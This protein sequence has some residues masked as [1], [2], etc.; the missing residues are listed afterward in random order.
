MIALLGRLKIYLGN[1]I[2]KKSQACLGSYNLT[3]C[4]NLLNLIQ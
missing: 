2:T 1:V 3:S 4:F